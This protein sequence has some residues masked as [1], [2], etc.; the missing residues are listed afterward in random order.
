[1]FVCV[2]S[3]NAWQ[4]SEERTLGTCPGTHTVCEE[5][6]LLGHVWY[7]VDSRTWRNSD[8]RAL[9]TEKTFRTRMSMG[10]CLGMCVF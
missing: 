2:V 10:K 3:R 1:V 4:E 6:Q 7:Y 9:T 5:Y 8:A